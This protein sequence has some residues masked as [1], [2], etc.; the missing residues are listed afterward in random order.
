MLVASLYRGRK[1]LIE[2]KLQALGLV[3]PEPF[4]SPPGT[5]LPF[6]WVRIRGN[7][8]Y[9]SGHAPLNSDGSLARPLGKVGADVSAEEAYQAARLTALSILAS[10]KRAL[11]DLAG[12][13]AGLGVPGLANW[14]PGF[15]PKPAVRTG[16][17]DLF[18]ELYE[19]E[20]GHNPRSP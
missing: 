14:R 15:N 8:A 2:T 12:E 11:G 18:F 10:L 4:I 9:I 20:Q 5:L 1:M 6:S 7:R 19:P 3:L 16:F 13:G 17:S